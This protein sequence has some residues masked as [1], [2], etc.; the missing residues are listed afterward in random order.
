MNEIS[1]LVGLVC[2]LLALHSIAFY[3][4]SLFLVRRKPAIPA[5]PLTHRPS[6]A[7]C[8]SAY[9]EEKNIESKMDRLL[10]IAHTYGPATVHVYVDAPSD[11]TAALLAPYVDR[12]DIVFGQERRGKTFGMNLLVQRSKSELLL[13]TDANVESDADVGVKLAE[14]F[15]DPSIGCTTAK[16]VYSNR[17]ETAT[18]SLGAIY[19][20][21]E[22]AIKRLESRS[23]GLVGCDGA[24]FM[25]RRSLHVAP[26]PELIDDLY[27]SLSI[28]IAGS[29]IVSVDHVEVYERSATRAAEEGRRKQRIA[30]QAW[31]VHRALWPRLRKLPALSLY[32]YISHR[33]M[34]W[35]MPFFAAGA[36]GFLLL[37]VALSHGPLFGLSILVGIVA[38]YAI[39]A[40]LPFPPFS[41]FHSA[42]RSLAGVAV[43]AY[44]SFAL[45]RTY[46]IWNP[47]MSVRSEEPDPDETWRNRR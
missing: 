24:M 42:V 39:G 30:C 19:W 40:S 31:N 8:V 16:L 32:A 1:A 11:G 22:E 13:F 20:A 6:L 46:T 38:S 5:A 7:I 29:R 12:A 26:P 4:L 2:A 27:I 34:K 44:E 47:A 9:N 14:P 35:L 23:M 25:M 36:V 43:G 45:G 15:A 41:L 37:A 33:P 21:L 18:A 10:E 17:R 28:L 3:P